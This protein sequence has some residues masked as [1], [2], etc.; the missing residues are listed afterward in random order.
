VFYK[1]MPC[2]P[3]V[4][5]ATYMSRF[6]AKGCR[7]GAVVHHGRQDFLTTNGHEFTRTWKNSFP[8]T[9]RGSPS[10]PHERKK[11]GSGCPLPSK[12]SED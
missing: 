1:F 12:D 10:P 8:E 5:H 2:K 4:T 7:F 9:I 3:Q 11:E 6:G